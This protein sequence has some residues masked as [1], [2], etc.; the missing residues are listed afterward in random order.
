MKQTIILTLLGLILSS[1]AWSQKGK[2]QEITIKNYKLKANAADFFSGKAG[3]KIS[4]DVYFKEGFKDDFDNDNTY[5]ITWKL[6][7]EKGKIIFE[8]E[9][10][11]EF[12]HQSLIARA[13][14][15]FGK[16]GVSYGLDDHRNLFISYRDL[17]LP[18]GKHSFKLVLSAVHEVKD[19]PD[20]WTTN[21]AFDFQE[22][23]IQPFEKQVFKVENLSLDAKEGSYG[24]RLDIRYN[25]H[26][27]YGPNEVNEEDYALFWHLL[28]EKGQEV[29][30]CNQQFFTNK[31]KVYL[32]NLTK[33]KKGTYVKK[34]R[35]YVEYKNIHLHGIQ[36][37]TFVLYVLH[38]NKRIKIHEENKTIKLPELHDFEEQEFI[39]KNLAAKASQ[40]N[41]VSGIN[42]QFDCQLKYNRI[43]VDAEAGKATI[44]YYFFAKMDA[45]ESMLYQPSLGAPQLTKNK[46]EYTILEY[47]TLAKKTVEEYHSVTLFIPYFYLKPKKEGNYKANI[48]LF[49]TDCKGETKFPILGTVA[50]EFV[51]PKLLAFTFDLTALTLAERRY[52]PL[53]NGNY[54]KCK[55][56]PQW[57]LKAGDYN[58]FLGE[59]EFNNYQG[60]A[61]SVDVEIS[62]GD[63]LRLIILDYDK[64]FNPDDLLG[65]IKLRYEKSPLEVKNHQKGDV[66]KLDYTLK[67]KD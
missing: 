57:K 41:G 22:K 27:T 15:P 52:D 33:D 39:I 30:N 29:F 1:T 26:L 56:D 46:K 49:V 21:I 47:T 19:F 23:T 14:L 5:D 12:N 28:D 9:N 13:D 31:P 51:K 54:E 43:L 38:E 37:L 55:P 63:P 53:Y 61:E 48:S 7:D 66:V 32:R 42:I 6:V 65:E 67:R 36:R 44:D 2:N 60:L 18:S 20:F 11:S 8:S 34:E 4:F 64:L 17:N 10:A 16:P 25:L 59:V 45:A 24:E 35:T 62:E 58:L 3:L 40:K 50:I